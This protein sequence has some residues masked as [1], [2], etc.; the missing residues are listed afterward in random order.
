L[1]PKTSIKGKVGK[2][3]FT[4]VRKF[5]LCERSYQSI[6]RQDPDWEKIFESHIHDKGLASQI[7]LITFKI[8]Q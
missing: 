5:L 1:T 6:K 7:Y 2:I 8:K 3:N 4:E